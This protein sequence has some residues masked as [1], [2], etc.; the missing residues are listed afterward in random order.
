MQFTNLKQS[1]KSKLIL[2]KARDLDYLN[3]NCT[4]V[5]EHND[6]QYHLPDDVSS[7]VT[8]RVLLN[9][10]STSNNV[11][12]MKQLHGNDSDNYCTGS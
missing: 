4:E 6:K 10:L 9:R 5:E 12:V 3:I 11:Y 1:V 8:G 2:W 7:T